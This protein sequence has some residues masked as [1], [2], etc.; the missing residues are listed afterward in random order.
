MVVEP[1]QARFCRPVLALNL[2]VWVLAEM[3]QVSTFS[4]CFPQSAVHPA[5][6]GCCVDHIPLLFAPGVPLDEF[7]LTMSFGLVV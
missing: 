5:L 2:V 3:E 7:I 1:V 4:L 6:F